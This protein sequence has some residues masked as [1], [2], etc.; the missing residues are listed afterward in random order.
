[1]PVSINL[2]DSE[3]NRLQTNKLTFDASGIVELV[4][5]NQFN[6]A[7]ST[8]QNYLPQITFQFAV[9][10]AQAGMAGSSLLPVR[11]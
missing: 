2:Q 4:Y 7:P 8:S 5:A 9:G 10:T 11:P 3:N 1:L 6:L